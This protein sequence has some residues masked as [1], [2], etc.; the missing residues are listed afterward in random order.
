MRDNAVTSSHSSSD[1]MWYHH[2]GGF[3]QTSLLSKVSSTIDTQWFNSQCLKLAAATYIWKR[4]GALLNT[5]HVRMTYFTA[6]CVSSQSSYR[7]T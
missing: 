3:L 2:F 4:L 6:L 1:S 5:V 7:C